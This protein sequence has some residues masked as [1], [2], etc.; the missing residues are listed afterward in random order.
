MEEE[1]RRPRCC[2]GAVVVGDAGKEED[3]EELEAEE[4]EGDGGGAERRRVRRNGEATRAAARGSACGPGPEQTAAGVRGQAVHCMPR[5]SGH[6]AAGEPARS[7]RRHRIGVRHGAY[8][9]SEIPWS[10]SLR[11][12]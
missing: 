3:V 7:G 10:L 12:K 11:Y 9:S 5:T 8:L 2:G 4:D 6:D 1:A